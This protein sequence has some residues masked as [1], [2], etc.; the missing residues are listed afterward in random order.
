MVSNNLGTNNRLYSQQRF[1][2][3]AEVS[4]KKAEKDKKENGN[5]KIKGEQENYMYAKHDNTAAACRAYSRS[6]A[7]VQPD[8]IGGEVSPELLQDL[9]KNYFD[10][11]V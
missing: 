6:N 2:D 7:V 10:K 11:Q 4:A 1:L 8:D 5:T 3:A 9:K